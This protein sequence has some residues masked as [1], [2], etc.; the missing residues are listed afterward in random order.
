M[1]K[2][3]L[4]SLSP[5]WFSPGSLVFSQRVGSVVLW[6]GFA[7]NRQIIHIV[8]TIQTRPQVTLMTV[9]IE[10]QRPIQIPSRLLIA[11]VCV[12]HL[13]ETGLIAFSA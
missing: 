6:F 9:A 2:E 11:E 8:T 1:K 5:V 7:V 4:V 10:K 3:D 13:K 12:E